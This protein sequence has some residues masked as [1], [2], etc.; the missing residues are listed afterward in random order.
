MSLETIPSADS[1]TG[2][3]THEHTDYMKLNLH[4]NNKQETSGGGRQQ[5]GFKNFLERMDHLQKNKR[6]RRGI[7]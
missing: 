1:Y 6:D 4:T 5:N 3:R 7:K 2:T